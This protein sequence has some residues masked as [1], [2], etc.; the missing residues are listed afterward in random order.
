MTSMTETTST[1]P[2]FTM[3]AGETFD[4]RPVAWESASREAIASTP[5]YRELWD[6][7]RREHDYRLAH[8]NAVTDVEHAMAEA[9]AVQLGASEAQLTK[10]RNLVTERRDAMR[11]KT[12]L[13]LRVAELEGNLRNAQTR[14]IV[15]GDDPQL[16]EFWANAGRIAT[17]QNFCTEYD[18]MAEELGGPRRSRP[19]HVHVNVEIEI[20]IDVDDIEDYEITREE[21][22]EQIE[23]GRDASWGTGDVSWSDGE[24]C[25]D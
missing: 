9:Q 5:L 1:T 6:E 19:G 21:V 15:D 7:A 12:A 8:P 24:T 25:A 23:N 20:K 13:E 14:Q 3:T 18:R 2:R 17:E 16:V 4:Y 10:L 22:I 11:A